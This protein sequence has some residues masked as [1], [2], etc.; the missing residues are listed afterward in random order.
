MSNGTKEWSKTDH[1]LRRNV[2]WHPR[3][4]IHSI[5][6]REEKCSSER[7]K[8]PFPPPGTPAPPRPARPQVIS[9]YDY[10]YE[11]LPDS[12]LKVKEV[13]DLDGG[14]YTVRAENGIG[15][16]ASRTI[17]GSGRERGRKGR[18]DLL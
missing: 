15:E 1:D 8:L 6:S 2:K 18:T 12:S 5:Y 11:I 4:K 7:S 16:P 17:K 3:A 14:S 13:T 10:R 9:E